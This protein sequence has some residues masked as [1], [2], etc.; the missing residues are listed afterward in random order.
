L[1]VAVL[2]LT[3][4]PDTDDLRDAPSLQNIPIMLDDGATV[5]VW[6]PAG[7]DNFKVLYPNGINYCS[8]IEQ[9]IT[10]ADICFILTEW[11]EI[12]E[13]D[14]CKYADLMKHAIVIDGRNCYSLKDARNSEIVYDS[15][16]RKAVV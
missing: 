4:K 16:G 7:F 10:N 12:R 11:K 2:G 14:L 9:A 1:T 3:F 8:S 5:N 6:D 15:I 13:F